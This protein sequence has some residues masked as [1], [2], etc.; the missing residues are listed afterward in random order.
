MDP[1]SLLRSYVTDGHADQVVLAGERVDF[2]G[3]YSFPRATPTSYKSNQ[4]KEGFYDLE[5]LVAFVRHITTGSKY[6]EYLQTAK[7]AK[8]MAVSVLDRKVRW[9]WGRARREPRGG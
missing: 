6:R 3:R 2:G 8:L 1:L 4:G 5:S 7:S 9:G